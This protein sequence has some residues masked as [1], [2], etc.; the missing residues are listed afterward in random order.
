M[1]RQVDQL[2]ADAS[3]LARKVAALEQQV[4]ELR[5]TRRASHTALNA[6]GFKVYRPGTGTLA[7]LMAADLGDGEAGFQT[8][9]E[10]AARYAR[11]ESGELTFGAPD[12]SQVAAT[13]IAARPEGGSLDIT[14][15][16]ISGGAQA[17]I[18]LA[19]SDSPLAPGDGSALISM[20]WDGAG[21]TQMIVDISGI[22]LPRSM[23]WGSISI[24][25]SA[26]NTPTSAVVSGLNV[27]GTTFAA[28]VT[29]STGA[30]GTQVTGVGATNVTSAGLT[31]WLT[32]TNTTATTVF[33]EITGQ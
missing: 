29:A 20:E 1:P 3:S 31:I 5:A 8:N 21:T 17:H 16:L 33:W 13:G 22:L 4:R 18:I 32:R 28:Q 7:A 6:G 10:D 2:P 11:L 25:P 23:A 24:T 19:S 15:G 9:S 30:P 14:S 27:L 26:A 12:V